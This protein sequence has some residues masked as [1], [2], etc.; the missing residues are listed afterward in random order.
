MSDTTEE[1]IFDLTPEDEETLVSESEQGDSPVESP[2]PAAETAQLAPAAPDPK[3]APQ[4]E[5][6]K[7]I[8]E[9]PYTYGKCT[10]TASIVWLPGELG[11]RDMIIG[12]R[13][14]LD[15]PLLKVFNERELL[16]EQI[17]EVVQEMICDL[18]EEL[19]DRHVQK[20]E[21][22]KKNPKPAPVARPA[23]STPAAA[24]A[25]K[26]AALAGKKPVGKAPDPAQK[27]FFD[28]F[29]TGGK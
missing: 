18:H 17:M 21:R 19:P 20:L 25:S 23:A 4:P 24:P 5:K 1:Q 6:P 12:V 15:A 29:A 28:L 7:G 14:H 9:D 2:Q 22:D 26:P 8:T 13:N 3:P 16:P 27:S 10:I 11:A